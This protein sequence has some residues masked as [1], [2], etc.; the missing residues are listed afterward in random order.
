MRS[1]ALATNGNYIFLTDHSGIGDGHIAPSTDKYDVETLNVLLIRLLQ[2]YIFMPE[3]NQTIN[4]ARIDSLQH[5]QPDSSYN[6]SS[7]VHNPNPKKDSTGIDNNMPDTWFL[8]YYPNP[9]KG[10]LKVEINAN[11]SE[12]YIADI[13][14]K[15]LMKI[16][17]F[18][19]VRWI[20]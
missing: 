10:L 9:C 14:G 1:I 12:L 16:S 19:S 6:D 7:F 3:C 2:Q 4:T 11:I 18:K 5:N 17:F 15:L 13:N 20:L 8:K